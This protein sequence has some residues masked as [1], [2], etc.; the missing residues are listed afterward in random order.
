[1]ESFIN[2]QDLKN[3]NYDLTF[4]FMKDVRETVKDINYITENDWQKKTLVP[5]N[6]EAPK[7]Y[8]LV[9]LHK[10][11]NPIRPVSPFYNAPTFKT[12]KFLNSKIIE[13]CRF[14]PKFTLVN[15]IDL[16]KKLSQFQFQNQNF[17]LVSFDVAN[18]FPSIPIHNCI[19]LISDSMD[20][21]HVQICVKDEILKLLKLCLSQNY[22][23]YDNKF[24]IQKSGLA[25]GS[26][27]SPLLSNIF[28]DNF[29]NKVLNSSYGIQ[30][31]LF[32]Y[33]YVDDII[34]GFSGTNRQ[35]DVFPNFLNSIHNNIKFTYEVENLEKSLN[36]L[37]LNITRGDSD[38]K[39]KIYRKDSFTDAIIPNDSYNPEIHKMASFR[40]WIHRAISV[41]M[42]KHDLNE[43]LN[44][45][46]QIGINNGFCIKKINKIIS[47]K[48]YRQNMNEIFPSVID[49]VV[50]PYISVPYVQNLSNKISNTFSKFGINVAFKSNPN[51]G[52]YLFNSKPKT[53]IMKKSGVYSLSCSQC[54]ATYVGQTGR[55]FHIRYCEHIR[56]NSNTNFRQHLNDSGHILNQNHKPK[57]LHIENKGIIL[58]L[59]ES[60][61]INKLNNNN[62]LTILND[63]QDLSNSP[64]LNLNL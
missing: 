25:M 23:Q 64:L 46:K 52:N 38:F 6:A 11:N 9:K 49:I 58:N 31:I 15:S 17:K 60:M 42:T 10:I 37:D 26:P 50:K 33:R 56:P 59:L 28:M 47:N 21:N 5:M 45:I 62:N 36:F 14:D 32:W 12:Q 57:I 20:K 48:I 19:Q 39:Y 40:S 3:I 35:I 22:F 34:V 53:D 16:I 55:S 61:E 24:Y 51:L 44:F 13:V 54:N 8:G 27:L 2:T 29:E 7:L 18:M 4:K 43:E 1:M 30:H 63:Q 41:P